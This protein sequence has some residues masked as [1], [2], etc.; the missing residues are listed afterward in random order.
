MKYE[1]LLCQALE[2]DPPWQIVRMR[3][4]LGRRQLDIWVA[5]EAP[6][7]GWIFGARYELRD[8]PESVW[9]HINV[10]QSR[11]VV[12]AAADMAHLGLPWIGADDQV[13]T[14]ALSRQIAT[15]FMEGISFQAICKLLDI[16]VGDLWKF[17]HSLDNG[18]ISLSG[19]D[20][21]VA[22]SKQASLGIPDADH[23]VWNALLTGALD[24]DI[25]LLSLKLLLTKLR[26]QMPLISDPEVRLMKA[27]ELH[28]YFLRHAAQLSH[29]LTQLRPNGSP[30]E[31][32][33]EM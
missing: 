12:H 13:F 23:P 29:E 24:L 21:L 26:G 4:D 17:K 5:R 32:T 25:R 9:R 1:D 7:R 33:H 10:G 22:D 18:K 6:R 30:T 15:H 20:T 16:P 2:I 11:C 31:R 3:N 8:G 19:K 28:H 14:H 27:H